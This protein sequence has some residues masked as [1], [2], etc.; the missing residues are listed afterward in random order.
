MLTRD[1]FVVELGAYRLKKEAKKVFF[2]CFEKRLNEEITHPIF[3][4]K[5]S[6]REC[7]EIQARLVA[8]YLSGEIP[9]YTP[10]HIR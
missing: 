9:E 7:I 10:L 3:G 6:Y 2:T 1:D 4:Y 8:K 5:K